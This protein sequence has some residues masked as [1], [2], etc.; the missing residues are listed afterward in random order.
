MTSQ[1]Y[2]IILGEKIQIYLHKLKILKI[3]KTDAA[4]NEMNEMINFF[5]QLESGFEFSSKENYKILENNPT[6]ARV[7]FSKNCIEKRFDSIPALMNQI[8]Y[9]DKVAS[10]NSKEQAEYLRE[11]KNINI[12]ENVAVQMG[13]HI[14]E[15]VR[16]EVIE[17]SKLQ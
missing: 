11:I 2:R 12:K 6:E 17:M 9:D 1:N 14:D 7:S 13:V 4:T 8:R 10:L 16:Q 5:N 15:V 3:L